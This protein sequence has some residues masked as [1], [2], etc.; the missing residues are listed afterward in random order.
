MKKIDI[1]LALITGEVVA[2]LFLNMFKGIEA[3]AGIKALGWILPIA[4]PIM[5]V[6]GLWITYLIGKKYLFVFQLGKFCLAGAFFT[7]IDVGLLD[8]L[9][10]LSGFNSG[11][12]YSLFKG[13]SFIIATIVKYVGSKFWVFEGSGGE[14][15]TQIGKFFLVTAIGFGINVGVAS[16][17]VNIIGPQFSLTSKIWANA[18]AII[19]TFVAM[20]WNFIGYK[21]IVFK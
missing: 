4:F 16:L 17:V 12:I 8:V 3:L 5:A 11:L 10:L 20:T 6:I 1:I 2:W 18:G 9:V 19:A 15:G 14:L 7:V 21:F 13:I